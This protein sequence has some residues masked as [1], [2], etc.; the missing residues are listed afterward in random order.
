MTGGPLV[1]ITA[2]QTNSVVMT[3][4]L[5]AVSHPCYRNQ[6][7][8]TETQ[9]VREGERD[10]ETRR[11]ERVWEREREGERWKVRQR[12]EREAS[13][14]LDSELLTEG[15]CFPGSGKAVLCVQG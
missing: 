9:V 11:R 8:W 6:E 10:G 7:V 4:D 1:F 13:K 12:R 2:R 15:I 14:R 3:A 5:P